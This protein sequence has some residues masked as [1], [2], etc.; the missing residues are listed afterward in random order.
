MCG[1][2]F[3]WFEFRYK[4]AMVPH[5]LDNWR[6]IHCFFGDENNCFCILHLQDP[7]T[8]WVIPCFFVC[9]I[10]SSTRHQE[11][12]WQS[13]I[14][15]EKIDNIVRNGPRNQTV[16]YC[17]MDGQSSISSEGDDVNKRRFTVP[18]ADKPSYRQMETT[19]SSERNNV[20]KRRITLPWA[21]NRAYDR[22]KATRNER[23]DR[24]LIVRWTRYCRYI[25][26][27]HRRTFTTNTTW[28]SVTSMNHRSLTLLASFSNTPQIPL[29]WSNT[30]CESGTSMNLRISHSWTS[31]PFCKTPRNL[32]WFCIVDKSS[33]SLLN[34]FKRNWLAQRPCMI[35]NLTPAAKAASSPNPRK[36]VVWF[37]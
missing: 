4:M 28:E 34:N 5:L 17:A 11:R 25:I 37:G 3:M 35:C 36:D 18:W 32:L 8:S 16:I 19:I 20:I 29:I 31:C 24:V 27:E 2:I 14:S 1:K 30:E 12:R 15:S 10:L 26:M 22:H 7:R 23:S 9:T 21:D 6:F 33:R 13:S